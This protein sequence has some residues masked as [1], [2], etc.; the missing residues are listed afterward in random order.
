MYLHIRFGLSLH[1]FTFLGCGDAIKNVLQDMRVYPEELAG[2][3]NTSGA[4]HPHTQTL[5]YTYGHP[6]TR[7]Y[8]YIHAD[9][10]LLQ[11]SM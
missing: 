1:V 11:T 9:T 8:T 6:H 2:H 5:T 3:E 10:K 4:G 7:T